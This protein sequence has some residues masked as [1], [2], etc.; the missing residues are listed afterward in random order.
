MK[1]MLE[2]RMVAARIQV[3]DSG[4]HGTWAFADPIT[5]SSQGVLM[6]LM[7]AIQS[8]GGSEDQLS[9]AQ[10]LRV[11]FLKLTRRRKLT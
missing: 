1:A 11:T 2:A 5:V 4:L 3:P 8:A 10:H 7:D 6:E 9:T